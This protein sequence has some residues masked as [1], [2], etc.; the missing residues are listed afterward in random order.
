MCSW[1]TVLWVWS[2]S[3]AGGQGPGPRGKRGPARL[4]PEAPEQW[5]GGPSMHLGWG[6]GVEAAPGKA[7]TSSGRR[8]WHL[9]KAGSEGGPGCAGACLPGAERAGHRAEAGGREAGTGRDRDRHR[10][11]GQGGHADRS[12]APGHLQGPHT[13]PGLASWSSQAQ[14][15]PPPGPSQARP[16]PQPMAAGL[17]GVN[18]GLGQLL[19]TPHTE[20]SRTSPHTGHGDTGRCL[21]L[22]GLGQRAGSS[23]ETRPRREEPRLARVQDAGGDW[24]SGRESNPRQDWRPPLEE[25]V[26]PAGWRLQPMSWPASQRG[27]SALHCPLC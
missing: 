24:T 14:S 21:G 22:P 8:A 13:A 23:H 12:P 7:D 15:S 4:G 3:A 9:S 6:A 18:K 20:A 26:G 2:A 1:K 27:D 16:Q 10:H 5:D 11:S 19:G 25:Q 17:R